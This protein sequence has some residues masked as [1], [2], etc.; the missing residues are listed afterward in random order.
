MGL[1]ILTIAY[2]TA[3]VTYLARTV[4]KRAFG[5]Y[6]VR[7]DGSRVGFGRALAR[8]ALSIF[9]FQLTMGLL[10]L[11][12][13]FRED[14]RALHDLLC[15]TVVIRRYRRPQDGSTGPDRR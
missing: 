12:A 15:D 2:H 11:V 7:C 4:G 6:V 5:L 3:L 8:H 10:F 1:T 9:S 13:L 14:R